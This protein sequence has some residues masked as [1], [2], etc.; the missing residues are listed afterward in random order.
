MLKN[1]IIP[2]LDVKNGRVVKGI[3]FVDLV[4][5]GDP[6]EQAKIYDEQGA[7]ELCFLDITAS[8]EN[9][10]IILDT[11]KKTAEKCF[12]PLTVGGG[13]RALEDIRNLLL[14]GADK[15]WIN[16]AAVNNKN[17]VKIQVAIAKG[18]QLH[19]KRQDLKAKDMKRDIAR[20][21]KDY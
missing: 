6:V 17:L 8:N 16:T 5:A 2:C 13:V 19:D 15:V 7:D 20:A 11:V 1:R 18:K 10:N 9:R 3:N 14:A 4:D 21:M 12:I